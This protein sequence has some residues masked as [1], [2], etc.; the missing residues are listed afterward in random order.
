MNLNLMYQTVFTLRFKNRYTFWRY[1]GVDF[2]ANSVSDTTLL[3][4]RQGFIPVKV[5]DKNGVLTTTELPNP[6]VQM[7]KPETN[8]VFSEIYV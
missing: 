1:I 4:T 6:A 8:Q 3:L 7:I 2:G 5:K